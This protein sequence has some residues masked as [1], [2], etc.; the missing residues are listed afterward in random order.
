MWPEGLSQFVER[1]ESMPPLSFWAE[2]LDTLSYGRDFTYSAR[3]FLS[4]RISDLSKSEPSEAQISELSL[5]MRAFF[6]F[7]VHSAS[8]DL[9]L[10]GLNFLNKLDKEAPIHS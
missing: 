1:L 6:G 10:E 2:P 4:T 8:N 3:T 5:G 7:A 9:I